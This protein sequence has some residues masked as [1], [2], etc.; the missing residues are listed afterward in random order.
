M[1]AARGKPFSQHHCLQDEVL[2]P[3]LQFGERPPPWKTNK[4]SDE[5]SASE[6]K[7]SDSS[8][9][10]GTAKPQPHPIL[11]KAR[12][13]SKSGPR[14]TAR[15][16]E[17]DGDASSGSA[18]PAGVEMRRTS[19]EMRR[20]RKKGPAPKKQFH[21]S[22]GA[23]RR[24]ALPRRISSQSS[25][26][27]DTAGKEE[28]ARGAKQGQRRST[29][30]AG[31]AAVVSEKPPSS[32]MVG[33]RL[34]VRPGLER[35]ISHEAAG[36]R[37]AGRPGLER[38]ISHE[39][40]RKAAGN[41]RSGPVPHTRSLEDVRR[42]HPGI[43]QGGSDGSNGLNAGKIEPMQAAQAPDTDPKPRPSVPRSQTL[44]EPR[45]PEP[46]PVK[47]ARPALAAEPTASTTTVAAQGTIIDFDRP[48]P[49]PPMA[50]VPEAEDISLPRQPS[51]TSLLESRLAPTQPS[52][53]PA[54]PLGRTRSQLTLLLERERERLGE[55]RG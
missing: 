47:A 4:T 8:A 48:P 14:P 17:E 46:S 9:K 1:G 33:K 54:V 41:Q 18:S 10:N 16:A 39:A 44:A 53:A 36:K 15:F 49:Q 38:R 43:P 23:K 11:K 29:E 3:D 21:A 6:S 35:R 50:T 28:G 51:A 32:K 20:E 7:S 5:S 34:A 13:D 27:P 12:V 42:Q 24:P 22:V 2:T 19:S 26:S 25:A 40:S 52:A 37:A 30:E 55:S 31:P 45:R